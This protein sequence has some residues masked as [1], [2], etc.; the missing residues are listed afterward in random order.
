MDIA[1]NKLGFVAQLLTVLVFNEMC[2]LNL[3][4]FV[5]HILVFWHKNEANINLITANTAESYCSNFVI[6]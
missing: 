3:L 1:Y 5:Y 2:L 4:L 6:V